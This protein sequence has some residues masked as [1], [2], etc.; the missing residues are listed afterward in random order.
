MKLGLHQG[1][2]ETTYRALPAMNSTTIKA[3]RDSMRHMKRAKESPKQPSPEMRM[4]TAL[5]CLVLEPEKFARTYRACD[6]ECD[7]AAKAYKSFAAECD[8]EGVE[9]L[10]FYEAAQLAEQRRNLM[11]HPEAGAILREGGLSEYVALWQD[12][13]TGFA[14]KAR[15]DR[16]VPGVVALDI[17]TTKCA[18]DDAFS[19]QMY[20]LGYWMQL[21]F[22]HEG[23]RRA[24]GVDTPFTIIAVENVEPYLV[25]VFSLDDYTRQCGI[26]ENHAILRRWA[27]CVRTGVYPGYPTG[28]RE[29]GIPDWAKKRHPPEAMEWDSNDNGGF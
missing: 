15:L 26:A 17:K 6:I 19:K 4:G 21:A 14:C 8:H 27:E 24:S 13:E 5:H 28:I 12:H 3:G 20:D 22:Y 2:D 1:M 7:K 11:E 10:S 18:R 9:P 16:Y 29:I 23:F 25:N